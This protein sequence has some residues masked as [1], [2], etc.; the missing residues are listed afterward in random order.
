MDQVLATVLYAGLGV[1][2]LVLA[3]VIVDLLTPGKLWQEILEKQN[4][5]LAILASGFAIAVAIIVASAI[6]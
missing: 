3:F 4:R 6:H 5:A 2:M 1:L